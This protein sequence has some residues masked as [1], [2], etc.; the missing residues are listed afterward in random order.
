V[1][2]TLWRHKLSSTETGHHCGVCKL[3]SGPGPYGAHGTC[4]LERAG[5]TSGHAGGGSTVHVFTSR[6]TNWVSI[7]ELQQGSVKVTRPSPPRTQVSSSPSRGHLHTGDVGLSAQL[8]TVVCG[9]LLVAPHSNVP[10]LAAQGQ[11]VNGSGEGGL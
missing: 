8:K 7:T 9:I 11:E 10:S 4:E 2:G 6:L 1:C 5:S 3:S